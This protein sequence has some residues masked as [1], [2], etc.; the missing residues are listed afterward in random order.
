VGGVGVIVGSNHADGVGARGGMGGGGALVD[1]GGG[2]VAES[3]GFRGRSQGVVVVFSVGGRVVAAVF[4]DSAST[5][6]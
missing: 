1:A 2:L 3:G 5:C 4:G 6:S